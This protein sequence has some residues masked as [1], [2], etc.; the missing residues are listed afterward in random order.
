VASSGIV[1]RRRMESVAFTHPT[2]QDSGK[3]HSPIFEYSGDDSAAQFMQEN[4]RRIFL[5]IYRIVKNVD[6]AQDLTQETFIKAWQRQGQLKTFEKAPHWLSRI[7]KHTALDFLRRSKKH[8]FTDISRAV[9]SISSPDESIE[10]SLLYREGW[11]YLEGGLAKLT[12]RERTALILRDLEDMPSDR[13]A[14]E[15]ACSVPTVRSHI[16]SARAKFKRYLAEQS[17]VSNGPEIGPKGPANGVE[18]ITAKEA[19]RGNWEAR[20]QRLGLNV[21]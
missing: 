14:V 13:V 2:G 15:M 4:S 6:D 12:T 21:K 20:E 19:D 10:Q 8:L 7:A 18:Q 9:V 1:A 3:L 11:S 16:S 17:P 5:I